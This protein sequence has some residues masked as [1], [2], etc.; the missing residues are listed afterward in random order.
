MSTISHMHS[1]WHTTL[2]GN[3]SH[4]F[5]LFLIKTSSDMVHRVFRSSVILRNFLFF[6]VHTAID[7][8]YTPENS[9]SN[10][11]MGGLIKGRCCM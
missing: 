3:I 10:K 5:P 6:T 7:S 4:I 11:I 2:G 1:K 9:N 8:N